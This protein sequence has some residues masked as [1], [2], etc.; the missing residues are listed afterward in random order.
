MDNKA[1]G[2]EPIQII[3]IEQDFCTRTYGT[4]PCMA[5]LGTTGTMKCFNT[6]ATC[7][8]ALNFNADKLT[9][10]YTK[11]EAPRIPGVYT[12][13]LL[14]SSSTAPTVINPGGGN[15]NASPLGQR[16]VLRVQM[17]DGQGADTLQDRYLD[18]RGYDHLRRGTYWSK[19]LARNLF[20]RNSKISVLDGYK[21][22]ALNQFIR[23]DYIID[24]IDG[25]GRG[26]EVTITAKDVLVLADD[27]KAKAPKPS[28]G[29][30]AEDMPTGA[31]T[32]ILIAGAALADYP[33][34]G[35]VRIGRECFAYTASSTEL[36]NIKLT[37]ITRATD[38]TT[39][40]AH[41]IGDK[42]QECLRYNNKRCDA[43]AYELLTVYGNVPAAYID[44]VAWQ[45][46]ADLWLNQFEL[47]SLITEPTGVKTLLGEITEQ[48][49]FHIWWDER[50]Q[51]I[52][53]EALKP[54]IY[55]TVP[56]LSEE[57]HIIADSVTIKDD[58]G[59]RVSQVWISWGQRDPT[60]SATDANNY[61]RARVS[62]NL[63]SE[64]PIRYGEA[65]IRQI[66][67]RWL[68]TEAQVAN[69]G[70]RLLNRFTLPPKVVNLEV[71][72]KDRD[73]WTGRVVDMTLGGVVDGSGAQVQTRYQIVS[74]EET[75][76]GSRIE[77]QLEQ[78]EYQT[79]AG[80]Y[81]RWMIDLAPDYAAASPVEQETGFFW[82]EAGGKMPNGDNG[83]IWS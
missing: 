69:V 63:D 68:Q 52:R 51:K 38:G 48:C 35:T 80:R 13:P 3:E 81:G 39:V 83:Y 36:T 57:K 70:V 79:I 25:P 2:R 77:L 11:P 27:D 20:Y 15:R 34:S 14:R 73:L 12:I 44:Y 58:Q 59:R 22:Q 18:E 16:A 74:A 46:E 4:A 9:L 42:V 17:M 82:A 78:Y 41:K 29:E 23:R 54:P 45:A 72:A 28:K 55:D 60:Q 76:A 56:V 1:S 30:L 62:A 64:L 47:T 53:L 71:D 40:A 31:I 6:L 32:R 43:I 33:S 21:G 61:S 67:S 19:W 75:D 7:Q 49:L 5:A 24:A 8:D 65:K 10:R 37:G 50:A 26:G 66:F